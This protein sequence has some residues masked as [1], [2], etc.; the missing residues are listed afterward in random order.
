MVNQD[1]IPVIIGTDINAY[2]MS[3]SFHE[4]YQT[5][6]YLIGKINMGFTKYSS[7]IE[8]IKLVD[9]LDDQDTFVNALVT[10]A[11]EIP[12]Q[13][14]KK[15]VLVGTNDHYVRLIIE[16]KQVL[17][18]YYVFSYLNEDLLNQLQNK[19]SF[20]QLAE[21]YGIAYPATYFH[22]AGEPFDIEITDFPVVVK[23]SN[24]I[25]Y[26]R[27]EFPNQEKV[28][29]LE[30]L[31]DVKDIVQ[32]IEDSGY[33]DTIIIQ[34]YI[35]GDDTTMWDAVLYL[36][37]DSQAQ[38]VALGQV[39]LQE[40]AATAI[41]NYTSI[42][43]RYDRE[44]MENLKN[45]LESLDYV[46]F[47][48]F[49]MKYDPRDGKLKVF[50]VNVRQGRSSYYVT[51]MG[52]NLAKYLVDDIIYHK[53][54]ECVYIDKENLFTIVPRYILRDYIE[55]EEIK[56]EANKLI[57]DKKWGNPLYYK[58]DKSYM[59]KLYMAVRQYRYKGKYKNANW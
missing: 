14:G 38:F 52:H 13:E 48:N 51:Q 30:S 7:I 20:Y 22:Q 35:P 21:E 18:E 29:R 37:Q 43:S 34:D 25:E 31:E 16:N 45:F 55:D 11:K 19:E 24:G 27:N 40:H 3:A 39:A 54:K 28:Y 26:Y 1:F 56:A 41:G 49:D 33:R 4:E 32:T 15:L 50:E 23:P 44:L 17:S 9:H 10:Y 8:Q 5:K 2:H 42:L 46:G 59:R 6:P 36:N 57:K 53:E 47:A 12:N 58:G